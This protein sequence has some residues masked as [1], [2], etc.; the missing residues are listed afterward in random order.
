MIV[1]HDSLLNQYK[2]YQLANHPVN[3]ATNWVD[4]WM[5]FTTEQEF[6]DLSI[7]MQSRIDNWP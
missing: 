3:I 6:K 2:L 1:E 4:K 5:H 7:Y